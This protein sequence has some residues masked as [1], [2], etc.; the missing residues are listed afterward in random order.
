[1]ALPRYLATLIDSMALQTEIEQSLVD[2]MT[3]RLERN[4][5]T[6][7]RLFGKECSRGCYKHLMDCLYKAHEAKCLD[8]YE[9]WVER[10]IRSRLGRILTDAEDELIGELLNQ[11][12]GITET[13]LNVAGVELI[14]PEEPEEENP[15]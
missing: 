15:V 4:L 6:L 5:G 11:I 10:C 14:E 2:S 3:R 8:D 9:K 12:T 1:M 7:E 13:L